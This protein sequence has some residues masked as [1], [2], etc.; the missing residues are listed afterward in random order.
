MQGDPQPTKNSWKNFYENC[1]VEQEDIIGF[2]CFYGSSG[3]DFYVIEMGQWLKKYN[4]DEIFLATNILPVCVSVHVYM[5][6]FMFVYVWECE[7]MCVTAYLYVCAYVCVCMC[8]Y[9]C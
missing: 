8:V 2:I 9:V 1:S 6:M 4:P 5:C 3:L 7:C